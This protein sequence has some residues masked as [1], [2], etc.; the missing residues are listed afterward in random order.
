[1]NSVEAYDRIESE[2]GALGIPAATP[3]EDVTGPKRVLHLGLA[4][5]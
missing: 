2:F 5:G 4:T 1:M 3:G